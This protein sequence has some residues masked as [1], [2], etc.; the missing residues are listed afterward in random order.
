VTGTNEITC[1]SHESN[2]SVCPGDKLLSECATAT[3]LRKLTE[4]FEPDSHL[5]AVD[6]IPHPNLLDYMPLGCVSCR[7]V[8]VLSVEMHKRSPTGRVELKKSTTIDN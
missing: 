6:H 5:S 8:V 1:D 7:Q 2:E 4:D 3:I